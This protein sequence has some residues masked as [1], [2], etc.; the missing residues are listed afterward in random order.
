MTTIR[1]PAVAGLFYPAGPAELEKAVRAYLAEAE[2]TGPEPKA[3]IVPHAGYV[4]SGPVA[5][6]GYARV[7]RD[8][9]RVVLLGPAHRFPVRGVATHSAEFFTTPLGRI[10]VDPAVRSLPGVQVVDAAHIAEHSLEVH[11]PFL[12]V[13]LGDFALL[14]LLV[15]EAKPD[16]VAAIL[17]A[18]WG[19]PETLIVVS[20]DLS[21]FNDYDTAKRMDRVTATAIEEFRHD[22]VGP[23]QACGCRPVGGLLTVAKRLGL[24][25]ETLDLRSSGDTAGGKREV[26]GYGT[27]AVV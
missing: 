26:V 19:G 2:G 18:A 10:R 22:K 27:F 1:E 20:T 13:A 23:Y 15:G 24:A 6:T 11:L 14:P 12:Q 3:L 25:V 21:H 4:Y 9:E 8:I 5:A 16:E 17:D 7:K